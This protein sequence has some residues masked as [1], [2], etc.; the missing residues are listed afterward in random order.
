MNILYLVHHNYLPPKGGGQVAIF[1]QIKYLSKLHNVT[2]VGVKIKDDKVEIP[3]NYMP[4]FGNTKW[5]FINIFYFFSLQKIIK[6]K[7]IDLLILEYPYFGWLVY[8]LKKTTGIKVVVRSQ[9]VEYQRIKHIGIPFWKLL[10]YYEN[11][12]HNHVDAVLCITKEDATIFKNN[13]CK[14]PLL[15]FPFG[16][17]MQALP[18]DNVECK[19]RVCQ[20]LNIP[21]ETNIL[22]FNG[23]LDYLPN[24]EALD[25][26]LHKLNPILLEKLP[27]Y[28]FIICGNQLPASYQ[29][30][31]QFANKNIIYCGFVPDIAVYNKAATI[32]VNPIFGGGGIKTK[33]I[34]ALA[35]N[36]TCVSSESGAIGVVKNTVTNKLII[37]NDGDANAMA[38]YIFSVLTDKTKLDTLKEY[39][40]YY[41]WPFIVQK[42]LV[43]LANVIEK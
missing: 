26:I 8:L 5:R 40:S 18:T 19:K 23:S 4:L 29:N 6:K 30:L 15:D 31:E 35:Y 42:M 1:N 13:G 27:N 16:T 12:V 10:K 43:Q 36:T 38:N 22:F 32:F 7:A 24:L 2:I 39:Y 37:C 25:F 34:E 21:F 17:N 41:Y 33:L 28:K 9:N 3:S 14:K 11:W 20:Q